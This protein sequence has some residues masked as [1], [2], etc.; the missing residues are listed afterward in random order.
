MSIVVSNLSK[1]YTTQIAVDAISFEIKKGEIVGFLGPNGAGKS[2]TMKMLT[3]FLPPTSGDAT[4][5]GFSILTQAD[6]VRKSIGYLPEHNP[7][8][9]DMYCR[10]YLQFCGQLFN[11]NTINKQVEDIIELV[12]L[13]Q[14]RKKKIGQLSKGYRQRIGL[15]Q[16]LLH[17][18]S[19]LILDEPTSGLDPN[20]LHE[21]REVIKQIGKEKTVLLSTH[22][23]QEVEAI[24]DRIII[25][26]HGKIVADSQVSVLKQ[27]NKMQEHRVFEVSWLEQVDANKLN[28][29]KD[30]FIEKNTS[31]AYL[32][33]SKNNKDLRPL[34]FDWS[35]KNNYTL[36]SMQEQNTDLESVFK[37]LTK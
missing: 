3:C 26:N 6:D 2:T 36:V 4:I 8:Y 24:C 18:P 32:I 37:Q 11:L 19:V 33:I 13:T 35:V 10:E 27:K 25:I 14:E 28:E 20:Q 7:L 21:I 12:G 30:V 31:S 22:I 34:L 23:M 16:A 17:Q 29:L 9:L 5:N 1:N 15:A